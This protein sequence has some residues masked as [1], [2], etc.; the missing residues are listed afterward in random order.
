MRARRCSNR[1]QWHLA[2]WEKRFQSIFMAPMPTVAI[3]AP[4][5]ANGYLPN[6]RSSSIV[7]EFAIIANPISKCV[8]VILILY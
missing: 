1:C 2:R 3:N 4:K 8:S 7:N 6:P 5:T